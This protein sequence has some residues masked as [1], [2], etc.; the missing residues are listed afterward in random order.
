ML[1]ECQLFG[2]DRLCYSHSKTAEPFCSYNLKCFKGY[3]ICSAIMERDCG[4]S[5]FEFRLGSSFTASD[6]TWF[7]KKK[8]KQQVE[9]RE[10]YQALKE[11]CAHL[12]GKVQL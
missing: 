11:V 5:C 8:H 12:K 9:L 3:T 1:D 2:G 4:N 7:K 10:V 6:S